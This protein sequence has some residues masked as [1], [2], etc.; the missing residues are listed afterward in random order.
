MDTK[1]CFPIS[2]KILGTPGLP[3]RAWFTASAENCLGETDTSRLLEG[4]R[5]RPDRL[6]RDGEHAGKWLPAATPAQVNT[7]AA[8]LRAK[9]DETVPKSLAFLPSWLCW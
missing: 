8:T 7:G 9:L 6:T 1:D 4:Y 5:K 3:T 2:P